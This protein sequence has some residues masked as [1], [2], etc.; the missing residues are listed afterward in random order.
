[1]VGALALVLTRHRAKFLFES[2]DSTVSFLENFAEL[3]SGK[4]EN[5]TRTIRLENRL[6]EIEAIIDKMFEAVIYTDY[7]GNIIMLTSVSVM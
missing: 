4:I 7:F 5:E 2:L 6:K 3:I 1:M